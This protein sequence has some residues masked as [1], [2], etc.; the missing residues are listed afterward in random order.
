MLSSKSPFPDHCVAWAF[1][2]ILWGRVKT[3][4]TSQRV[5]GNPVLLWF[6]GS[7]TEDLHILAC[8]CIHLLKAK[9]VSWTWETLNLVWYLELQ[10]VKL[11]VNPILLHQRDRGSSETREAALQST[12]L[13][14]D[15]FPALPEKK[16]KPFHKDHNQG[17]A[18]RGIQQPWIPVSPKYRYPDWTEVSG[19]TWSL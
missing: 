15:V 13:A 10:G 12:Q 7:P 19:G 11:K 16:S 8:Y 2:P 14:L 9:W 6:P 4:S 17:I 5:T 1:T 3:L 18:A